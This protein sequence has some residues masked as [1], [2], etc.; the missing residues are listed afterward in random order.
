MTAIKI[1]IADL[2]FASE[3]GLLN[4]QQVK[5]LWETLAARSDAQDKFNF[6]TVALYGGS[7]LLSLGMAW[8]LLWSIID[9][10]GSVLFFL[11]FMYFVLFYTLGLLIWFR[12]FHLGGLER[13]PQAVGGVL[14]TLGV[15]MVGLIVLGIQ[16]WAGWFIPNT[17][18]FIV[19]E[20][21]TLFVGII[22]ILLV[23]GFPL[24]LAPIFF[25]LWAMLTIDL[26]NAIFGDYMI[27]DNLARPILSL[28]YGAAI[29]AAAQLILLWHRKRLGFELIGPATTFSSDQD[30]E[31]TMKLVE[32]YAFWAFI[33]GT[34][35]FWEGLTGLFLQWGWLATLVHLLFSPLRLHLPV[36]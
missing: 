13:V 6:P 35:A 7:L 29:L 22:T 10:D 25:S 18:P 26:E 34:L 23:R 4:D 20:S 12:P 14:L 15:F 8:L 3:Q 27:T 9:W 1:R 33:F 36:P 11:S 24:L 28:L 32:D 21:V 19:M 2:R 5:P 31:D 17:T 16:M 30:V